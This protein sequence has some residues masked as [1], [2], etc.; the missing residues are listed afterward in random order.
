[1]QRVL[2]ESKQK[3]KSRARRPL[4]QGRFRG[5][6]P[7][8][9]NYCSAFS[10]KAL[11]STCLCRLKSMWNTMECKRDSFSSALGGARE[12]HWERVSHALNT[13]IVF[14]QIFVDSPSPPR[15][16]LGRFFF[17]LKNYNSKTINKKKSV[18]VFHLKKNYKKSRSI[19]EKVRVT[20]WSSW[21]RMPHIHFFK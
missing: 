7:L 16:L 19:S 17:F 14:S 1:M 21:H 9:C 20:L 4:K 11:H 12:T 10:G 2:S 18:E 15:A 8:D 3:S 6:L 13:L 5:R